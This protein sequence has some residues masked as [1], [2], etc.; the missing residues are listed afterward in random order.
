MLA[1]QKLGCFQLAGI[2]YGS[3]MGPCIIMLQHVVMVVDEWH[4][5]GP[6]DLITASLSIQNAINKMHLCLLSITFACP[7]HNP[8]AT[9]GRSIHNV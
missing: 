1:T 4:N 5:S 3:N 7:Y 6:Q 8:T 2:V 9:T